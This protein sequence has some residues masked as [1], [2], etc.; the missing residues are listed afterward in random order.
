MF[1]VINVIMIADIRLN[2]MNKK[3]IIKNPVDYFSLN[4]YILTL[5]LELCLGLA[6]NF[7]NEKNEYLNSTYII[8]VPNTVTKGKNN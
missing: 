2:V 7:L 3:N 8:I 1:I 5:L 6:L 4:F